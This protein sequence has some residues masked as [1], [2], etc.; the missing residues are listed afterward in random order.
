M[1][2]DLPRWKRKW[3]ETK[4]CIAQTLIIWR[5]EEESEKEI[6][7]IQTSE[8]GEKVWSP[9]SQMRNVYSGRGQDPPFEILLRA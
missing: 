2:L 4:P 9:R 8:V 5:K 7:S 6:E 3:S 1:E